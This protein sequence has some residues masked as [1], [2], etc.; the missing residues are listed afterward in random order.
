MCLCLLQDVADFALQFPAL[1]KDVILPLS[2]IG[3]YKKRIF[4]SVLRV[5]SPGV[6]LW[7]HYDVRPWKLLASYSRKHFSPL[8]PSLSLQVMDNLLLQITGQKKVV[9]FSPKDALN[10]Y[11]AG[12]KSTILDI[13]NVNDCQ[14]PLFSKAVRYECYLGPGDILFIPAL[15]FH[16]VVSLEFS[17]AVNVFW[18]NLDD[19][20]YDP[21]DTYGNKD[22][23]QAQRA[24]QILDRA[25]KCLE[26]LP[27]DHRDFYA[28]CMVNR[29]QAKCFVN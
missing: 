17:V 4:S 11:L 22:P 3:Q 5:G 16:N 14:F 27:A 12:D 6:R 9:L 15:W 10:L 29:I 21:K 13:D 23:P 7:T 8:S 28:R 24:T 19:K 20:Y 18:R 1:A 25:I 2:L 26:E